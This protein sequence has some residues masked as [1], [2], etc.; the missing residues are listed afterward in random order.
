M[1]ITLD[2]TIEVADLI[3]DGCE[4]E[5]KF[6]QTDPYPL[7]NVISLLRSQ[8]DDKACNNVADILEERV[9]ELSLNELL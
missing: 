5:Y 9:L 3:W 6:V 4:A 8:T 1:E 2:N 7:F